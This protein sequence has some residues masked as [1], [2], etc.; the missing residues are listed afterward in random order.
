[1]PAAQHTRHTHQ[2]GPH[3]TEQVF[4]PS[5]RRC[6]SA[7]NIPFKVLSRAVFDKGGHGEHNPAALVLVE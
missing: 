5:A 1:M 4:Q 2:K 6:R 3:A 7:V